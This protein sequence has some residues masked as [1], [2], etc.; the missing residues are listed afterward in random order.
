M[1]RFRRNNLEIT[2][3]SDYVEDQNLEE[4]VI[5]IDKIDVNVSNQVIAA[6]HRIGK[7]NHLSKTVIVQFF[8]RKHAKKSLFN[9]KGLKNINRTSI[10]LEKLHSIFIYENLIQQITR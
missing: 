9:R 6:C 2:G 8:K 4:K 1:T 10:G 3:I 7:P 5:E